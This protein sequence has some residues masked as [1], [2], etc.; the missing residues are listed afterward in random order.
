MKMMNEKPPKIPPQLSET[1][2]DEILRSLLHK[3][4]T[5][6]DWGKACQQLHQAG[7]S[8]QTIFEQTGFQGSQQNLII[9][10]AKVYESLV[11]EDTTE[12]ILQY[13]QGP[14]SDILYEFRILNQQQRKAV[15]ELTY[16]KR[17]EVDEAKELA[18]AV[19]TFARL[20]QLPP[21]FTEHPGDAIAYQ[22]WK[23]ARQK[24]DL[25][26]RSR[27][28]AKGLKFAYS[29]TARA[30][31]EQLLSD[32]T[33]YPSRTTPL[34]PVYRLE[35]EEQLARMVP[36]AG[37][38]PLTHKDIEAISPIIAEEPFQ[39]ISYAGTGALVPLPGWQAVLKAMDP[40]A[41][42]ISSAELPTLPGKA[43][44]V[45]VVIDRAI[46]EWDINSY[47]LTNQGEK[48]SFQ[49]FED[50]PSTPLLGQVILVLRPKK[51][52]DENNL[53]EPWQMD[54]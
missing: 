27:L 25:P 29:Q 26:A 53:L 12:E 38:L 40:L 48:L 19:Q 13:F 36:F 1:E 51:I 41:I 35:D 20:S 50:E 39:V 5:W 23:Q 49:W 8:P 47:F 22:A 21:N 9:V 10:A 54:D 45:L 37:H 46:Q 11:K 17:L 6:V 44:D 33:V 18:K 30:A 32:F 42:L 7:Y 4:G 16:Q 52:F 15:A 34:M 14:R 28:I 2:A 31:I 24:K 3:E 43:E